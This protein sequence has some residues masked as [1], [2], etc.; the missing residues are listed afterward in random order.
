MA[1][2]TFES[3]EQ[4]FAQLAAD[5]PTASMQLAV[6][7]QGELALDL[8]TGPG[9]KPDSLLPVFSSTKGTIGLTIGRLVQEG[10][11]DLDARVADYW[12][13]FAQADK[14]DI[15]VR[16]ALSHQAGLH[17]VTGGYT[18]TELLEHE[19]LAAKLAAQ[20]PH[21]RVGAGYIYH[22]ITIGTIG[23]ELV[24]RTTGRTLAD[25]FMTEIA[26][27]RGIDVH[28]GLA[29]EHDGR[30]VSSDLPPMEQ[31]VELLKKL[32][33]NAYGGLGSLS[34]WRTDGGE[35]NLLMRV[36]DRDFQRVGPPAAGGMATARGLARMY[37]AVHRDLGSGR[38]LDD[39]TVERMT[40]VQVSGRDLNGGEP[41]AF[42]VVFQKPCR[43]N[44]RQ[45]FGSHRAFGHDGAGGSMA[46]SDPH[47]DFTVGYVT[48]TMALPET[49]SDRSIPLVHA[50]RDA[51][52]TARG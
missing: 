30:V 20:R 6:Y 45:D 51:I 32:P 31:L 44:P 23:D 52:L 10:V 29:A 33:N 14:A 24:R 19:P 8:V 39:E 42:G 18:D 17:G 2:V 25:Y 48:K 43:S 40:Q 34:L 27:P 37:A 22:A 5:D 41:M 38:I 4:L 35:R 26:A 12:P 47:L 21:W 49:P 13:E 9:F 11:I 1:T 16:Q 7:Y 36:N 50:V 28:V 3:V 46:M 15:T